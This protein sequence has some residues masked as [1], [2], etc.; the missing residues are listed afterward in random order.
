[1]QPPESVEM[2][3][4]T[5]WPFITALGITLLAAGLLTN[6]VFSIFG[7]VILVCGLAGWAHHLMPGQ[8][9]I[10]EPLLAPDHWAR[11]VE[12]AAV[13]VES[14]AEHARGER[15]SVP[16][17]IHPYA[18]GLKGG[19]V[20]GLVMA[21]LA[22]GYGVVTGRGIWYP[23]NLLAAMLLPSLNQASMQQLSQFSLAGLLIGLLIHA[24]ASLSVGL[25]LAVL[26]PTLPRLP[27]LFGGIVA[28]LLWT[29][30]VYALMGVLNPTMSA[31]VDWPWFIVTQVAFGLG[32]GLVISRTEK[33]PVA[34]LAFSRSR[35][36]ASGPP[37]GGHGES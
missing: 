23:V 32:A 33:V 14:L 21:I 3:A 5:A 35:R 36:H 7:A 10:R 11:P 37:S 17:W 1:M 8:G 26:W 15:V 24:V 20:G 31:N 16:E 12:R 25:C 19:V 9:V 18:A 27:L 6:L 2:P 29:G 22:L 13:G 34:G 4:P 28:P 30:A